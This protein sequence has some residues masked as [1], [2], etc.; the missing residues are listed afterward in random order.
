MKVGES[1][2]FEE[3]FEGVVQG[4]KRRLTCAA[5]LNSARLG[6]GLRVEGL[7]NV[8]QEGPLIVISNHLHTIDPLLTIASFP[9][10]MAFMGKKEVFESFATSWIGHWSGGFPVDRGNADRAALRH[11]QTVLELGVPI[12]MYPEGTR[13]TTKALIEAQAGAGFITLRADVPILPSAITGTERLPG[14]G[15]KGKMTV[16]I[17]NPDRG[18]KGTRIVYGEPFRIPKT[19]DGQ[20]VSAAEATEIM[21]LEIARLLPPDYRG[22]YADRLDNETSRRIEPV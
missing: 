6:I 19:I 16:D 11:A 21:M 14:A 3:I 15:E 20:R 22:V 13:S 2:T 9:R 12:G 4:R 18:H 5:I 17:P 7:E 10:L 8:P 1:K